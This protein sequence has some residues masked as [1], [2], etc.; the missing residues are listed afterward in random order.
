MEMSDDKEFERLREVVNGWNREE[1]RK[2][3]EDWIE[4]RPDIARMFADIINARDN[5]K[6]SSI[7]LN[8]WVVENTT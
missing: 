6:K 8:R 7:D 5:E 1:N 3:V 2:V 4:N